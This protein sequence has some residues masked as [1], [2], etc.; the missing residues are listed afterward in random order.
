MV[1]QLGQIEVGAGIFGK[2]A[3]DVVEEVQTKVE[4]TAGDGFA[5]YEHVLLVEMP[6]TRT[7]QQC[8]DLLVQTV[9]FALW[10][11][12]GDGAVNG[13]THVD[14]ALNSTIPRGGVCVF[15][16]GHEHLCARIEGVDDHFSIDWASDLDTA[17]LQICWYGS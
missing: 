3:L 2:E 11:S 16:V 13:V 8:R 15:K 12:K 14:L 9:L 1:L 7:H 10:A 17:V 4:D 5:V 6:A